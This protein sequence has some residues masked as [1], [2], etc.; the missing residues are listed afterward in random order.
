ML[1]HKSDPH[2]RFNFLVNVLDGTFLGSAFGFASFVTIIPLFVSGMTDSAVLIGLSSAIH[3]VG[4]QLPQLL[5]VDKVTRLSRF[6]PM[7]LWM[8]IHERVPFFGLALVAWFLPSLEVRIALGLTFILLIWQALGGGFTATAW[9]TMIGKIMPPESR[10]T[11]FGIQSAMVNLGG[12]LSAIAAGYL[13]EWYQSPLNFTLCFILAGLAMGLSFFFLALTRE[14]L[15]PPMHVADQRRPFWSH[16]GAILARDIN[17][18]WF[19]AARS[20]FQLAIMAA[21]FYAVYGVR[22][23]H[24]SEATAGLMTGVFMAAQIVANPLMGWAGDRWGH[25]LIM[26]VGA[27]AAAASALLAWLAPDISWFYL[28]FALA[29]VA[30]IASWTT[31]LSLILEF[32][33]KAEKPAYIGLANTLVAPS[34]LL[35]PI[36]GGWL[37][38]TAGYPAMFAVSAILGLLTALILQLLMHDPQRVLGYEAVGVYHD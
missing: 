5:T 3:I 7:V 21:G 27:Y 15:T 1:N 32:G 9:Q 31:P 20:M 10:G 38:D 30:N 8:T 22:Y 24:M 33:A 34:T 14:A 19:L 2:Y 12:G 23:H 11:F 37:A 25:R 13:L 28:V 36:F 17:F 16:S 4:W 26:G 35:A 18:R 6:K 29:G